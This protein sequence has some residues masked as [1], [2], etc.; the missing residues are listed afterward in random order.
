LTHKER[1]L[2][3][4]YDKDVPDKLPHGDVTVDPK[5]AQGVF[6]ETI[7]EEHGNFLLYW[8]TESFSDRFF[9]RHCRLRD[10]LGFD[11]AHVFPR[12]PFKKAGET[13]HFTGIALGT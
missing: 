13:D 10:F 8:M 5:I 4:L 9:E 3:V 11:F 12:E 6:R 1:M 7:P 2:A